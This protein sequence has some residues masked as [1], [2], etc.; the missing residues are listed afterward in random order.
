MSRP[1]TADLALMR[2]FNTTTVMECLR[3]H[4]PLSR[5]EL[6]VRTGL[7]RSTISSIIDDLIDKGYVH[8]TMLQDNKIGRP[9]ILLQFNPQGGCA[10]GIEI[11]VDF[12]QVLL[13]NFTAGILWQRRVP[14]TVN[15]VSDPLRGQIAVLERAETMI[16][17]AL[18][19]GKTLDLRPLG[20]GVGVP[21]LVD[22]NQGKLVF[23]PNLKWQDTPI[24]L[25]WTRRFNL[26]VFVENEANCAALG[27]FYYGVA[28]DVNDFI[29]ISTGIGLGGGIM[30]NGHLFKGSRG[31]AGEIGHMT[32]YEDGEVCGCGRRGC[33][34]TYA[35]PRALLRRVRQVLQQMD[36]ASAAQSLLLGM[37]NGEIEQITTQ[38]VVDAAR[39]G[40]EVALNALKEVGRHL[41]IGI[42]N[43][44]NI[45]NPEMVVLGGALS[46]YSPWLIPIIREYT[47][48]NLL[49]PLRGSLRIEASVQGLD[50]CALGA[51]TLVLDDIVREPLYS[52]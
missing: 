49:P 7:N 43:L 27:E 31:Y 23:A 30:L 47:D 24:R 45:F 37:V 17:E 34:E 35:G 28:H 39:H 26:P 18:E 22:A 19:F 41:A 20:I 51:A 21:G 3:R 29:H 33:W 44:A 11:G 8:E 13:T 32:I 48:K 36:T 38:H 25:M 40:D 1:K 15:D 4:A 52:I 46:L 5:A 42:T 50:A 9:G 14:H 12:L 10:V 2:K 16:S 6:S